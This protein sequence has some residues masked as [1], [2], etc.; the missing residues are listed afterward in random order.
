MRNR[1]LFSELK[2]R[3]DDDRSVNPLMT[4]VM[5][6]KKALQPFSQ[7]NKLYEN[8]EFLEKVIYRGI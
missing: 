4:Y 3:E 1:S 2:R 8:T 6:R 7:E 5:L